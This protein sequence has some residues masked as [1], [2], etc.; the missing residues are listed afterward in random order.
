MKEVMI[1]LRFIHGINQ[2][3]LPNFNL[4][5]LHMGAQGV[6]YFFAMPLLKKEFDF[7]HG[8]SYEGLISLETL[9]ICLS[10]LI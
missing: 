7:S 5:F 10:S 9:L 4:S 3:A 8:N 2:L 6:S 1:F